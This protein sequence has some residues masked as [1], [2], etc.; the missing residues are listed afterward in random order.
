MTEQEWEDADL[1]AAS[2]W[3]KYQQTYMRLGWTE[4]MFWS[5]FNKQQLASLELQKN[6]P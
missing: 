4:E 1:F 6:N 2:I 3:D 5:A